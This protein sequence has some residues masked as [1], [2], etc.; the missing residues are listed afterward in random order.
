[1]RVGSLAILGV[2]FIGWIAFSNATDVNA[3]PVQHA[4]ASPFLSTR[5]TTENGLPQ[6]SVTSIV[7]TPDGY[8][9][10]GTFGG[11]GRFDGVR[12]TIFNTSNTPAL[13][14]NRITALH[15]GRDGSLWIGAETGE[16]TRLRQGSFILFA[17]IRPD[18]SGLKTIRSIYEDRAGNVWV[19]ADNTGLRR[20]VAGDASRLE[21]YDQRHG[22]PLRAVNRMCED[23]DG[24]LWACAATGLA[25]FHEPR[26]G[27]PGKFTIE[28]ASS[29]PDDR[30][31]KI[32]PHPEGGL[33]LLTRWS[34]NRFYNGRLT[35]YLRS[36]HD[37]DLSPGICETAAGALLYSAFS[38]GLLKFDP[39]APSAM[40]SFKLEVDRPA[41][42]HCMFEDR[43]GNV[44]LGTI[45]DGLL[46][47]RRRRVTMLN[48]S[49]GLPDTG[50]NSVLED[51]RG[52]LWIG[53]AKG[54]CRLSAGKL[55]TYFL[56]IARDQSGSSRIAAIHEE[57]GGALWFGVGNGVVR[58]SDQRFTE[59][60]L[61]GLGLIF[62]ITED[63]RGQMWL[64]TDGGLRRFRDGQ[65]TSF[66]RADGLVNNEVKHLYEDR[67]G[68][69]WLGTTGGLSRF[70]DNRF[71]NYTTR[72]GLSN[73]TVRAIYEDQDGALWL[74]T[75]G[76][77]LNR[78]RNGRITPITAQQGLYD[79][80]ISSLLPDTDGGHDDFWLLGNR[81]VFRVSRR[82]L[83]D[84]ADG[85]SKMVRCVVYNEA[86]GMQPSEGQ[87]GHQPA[88][89]R[90]RDGR[91]Y[92]STIRG[93]AVIDPSL[94]SKLPPPIQ[95]ER[96]L[97]EGQEQD[98][99]QAIEIPPGKGNLEIDY[100]GLSL[101]KPEQV[102]F[103]FQLSGL[104]EQWP[105]GFVDVGHR[106]TAYFPQLE[107]GSYRF[108]VRAL[109][110]DGVWSERAAS[111]A[112]VVRPPWWRTTWFRTFAA[113]ALAGLVLA[114][115]RWREAI[116]RARAERQEAF[117]RQLIASQEQERKRIAAEL[118]DGLGQNLLTIKNWARMGL[119]ML[120]ADNAAQPFLTE[121]ADT[122]SVT[123]DDVRQMAQNLR[124]SQLERL[125]LTNT[126]DYMLR[127]VARASG[128]AF[129]AELDN[130]DGCLSPEAEINLFRVVQECANNIVKHSG[131]T[132]AQV[133]LK[134]T[135]TGLTLHCEDNGRGFSL[136]DLGLRIADSEIRKSEVQSNPQS[137]IHNPQSKGFG[138]R[139]MEERVNLLGGK[140]TIR[141]APEAGTTIIISIDGLFQSKR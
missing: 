122:T 64:G 101:G 28:L 80:F 50:S 72:E 40:T 23:R 52:N 132:E 139:W 44:W 55:T 12:F 2:F 130:I 131:A 35:N 109:S 10:L 70:Q 107:P 133:N 45:G 81:G 110:P 76:G 33:W 16:I 13:P 77:G 134:R 129:S 66:N 89:W 51:A 43:E 136:A 11:L 117:S 31:N 85:R 128:I 49:S 97:V 125:G 34:L 99:R 5:W 104:N 69:L 96:V 54:L 98:V 71:T 1:M 53:T 39:G 83:N 48:A 7:Q 67:A 114:G 8:L 115:Y 18:E 94:E 46:R 135:A 141:S 27:A 47:L 84:V 106:R 116:Y 42:V 79:D 61:P 60:P 38:D 100:T 78:L 68:A 4:A 20:Y 105:G 86:D 119:R 14:S 91:L 29:A 3:R 108:S 36:P 63:R 95:I 140:L 24:N 25:L 6:N 92:F 15:V 87:G 22:L 30:M 17:V 62:A 138:L 32:L 127:N 58:Y 21:F 120:P 75:Y 74:G 59:Y 26:N 121:I 57:H 137:A 93:A 90:A 9:W 37:T 82:A 19:S 126:L 102:Q 112:F 123:I 118:H 73:N 65:I 56:P 88:G 113:M 41:P 111:L 124:P 103:S